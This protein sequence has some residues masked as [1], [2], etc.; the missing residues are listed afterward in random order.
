ML[1]RAASITRRVFAIRASRV[2]LVD[3]ELGAHVEA[4]GASAGRDELERAGRL[5]SHVAGEPD[6]CSDFLQDTG[7][8]R[9]WR[10]RGS[11]QS[12]L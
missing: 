8:F 5:P 7:G 3:L 10:E 12:V 9:P 2:F 11:S 4:A 1:C 6:A